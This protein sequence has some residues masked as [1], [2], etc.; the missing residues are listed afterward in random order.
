VT[1]LRVVIADDSHVFRYGLRLL[2]QAAEDVDV[3]GEAAD[4]DD[5]VSV[6][7]ETRP[8]V[9]VMDLHM[10]GGGGVDATERLRAQAPRTAVLVLTMQEDGAWLRRALQAGARGYLLKDADPGSVVRAVRTVADGAAYFGAGAAE[11]VLS[12]ASDDAATYP[13]PRSP[14]ASGRSWTGWPGGSATTRSRRG[15][16]SRRRRC[17]TTSARCCSSSAS[18]PA[19]RPWSSPVTRDWAGPAPPPGRTAETGVAEAHRLLGLQLGASPSR[20]R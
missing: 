4:T 3:V 7:L 16:A 5:A 1:A 20:P 18:P 13:F 12:S 14:G 11:H 10:P 9:V 2:L 6:V 8:D 15:S 19:P 17:R